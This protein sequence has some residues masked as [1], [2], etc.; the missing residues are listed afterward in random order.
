VAKKKRELAKQKEIEDFNENGGFP[1]LLKQ[2]FQ[3]SDSASIQLDS[4][5]QLKNLCRDFYIRK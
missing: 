2:I 1:K 5:Y 3:P 4:V